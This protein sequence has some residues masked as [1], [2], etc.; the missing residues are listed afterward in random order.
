MTIS[1]IT[2][3]KVAVILFYLLLFTGLALYDEKPNPEMV[4]D[5]SRPMP[6]VIQPGNAWIAFLGFNC[7]AE[8]SPFAQG[9]KR[10]L[11]VKNLLRPG[12]SAKEFRIEYVNI[13]Q[14][15]LNDKSG[16]S[17]KG[18]LPS[19]YGTKD[20]GMLP[21]AAAHQK[22]IDVLLKNNAELLGRYESLSKYPRYIEPLDLGYYAP[23]PPWAFGNSQEMNRLAIAV[24]ASHGDVKGALIRLKKDIEFWRLIASNSMTLISKLI[25]FQYLHLDMLLAAEIGADSPL[26]TEEGELLRGILRPFDKGEISQSKA[27]LGEFRHSQKGMELTYHLEA[28]RIDRLFFKQNAFNNRMYANSQDHIHLAELPP[29]EFAI[30][31][32]NLKRDKKARVGIP[33]LYNP[34]GEILSVI[35]Q[36][37]D[38]SIY[39]ER[40]YNLEGLRRLALLKVLIHQENISSERTQQFLDIH[41]S[42]L[43]NPYTG[44]PMTWDSKE[45]SIS[46][47]QLSGNKSVEILL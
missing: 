36:G 46:F 2:K 33:F 9:E 42:D 38:T 31:V 21:Y 4:K 22:E 5:M 40:G 7:P 12:K 30:K 14:E 39:I 28:S 23:S 17:F 6:E 47:K 43:G 1:K 13:L 35:A 19:F 29:K 15:S 18:R 11:R 3:I 44:G 41:A 8:I 16:L 26:K 45:R 20:Q 32:K 27:I 37:V 34:A 10:M 24:K 25:A